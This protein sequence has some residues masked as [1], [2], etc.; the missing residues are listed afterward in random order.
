MVAGFVVRSNTATALLPLPTNRVLPSAVTT[1]PS[2]ADKGF[3]PLEREAQHWAPGNPPNSPL[4]PN[5]GMEKL[6]VRQPKRV[7][8]PSAETIGGM[9]G[10][11]GLALL[12]AWA[13][14]LAPP[15]VFTAT[16]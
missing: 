3:T 16:L 14:E 1:S 8:F 5:P 4:A 13:T 12:P 7:K 9:V 6:P 15:M 11:H 2:G 10:T